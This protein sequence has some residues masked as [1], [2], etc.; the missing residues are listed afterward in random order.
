MRRLA[1][2][3]A[4]HRL[5]VEDVDD[6]WT[7]RRLLRPGTRVG[8]LGGRRD[9]STTIGIEGGRVKSAERK[10]MWIELRAESS[11]HQ[12]FADVLRVHGTITQAP[13]DVGSHHTH[14]VSVRDEVEVTPADVWRTEDTELLDEALASGRRTRLGIVVVEADEVTLYELGRH[15]LREVHQFTMRGGGKQADASSDVRRSFLKDAAA[16]TMDAW[17]ARVPLLVCGPGLTRDAVSALLTDVGDGREVRSVA[18]GIGG[19]GAV[20]EVL[21]AGEG[22]A[23]LADHAL[24][25]QARLVGEALE[26]LGRDGAVAYGAADLWAAVGEGAVE[27]A[28]VLADRLRE[29][30]AL[31]GERSLESWVGA[32]REAGGSLVQCSLDDE[33]G[34]QLAGFGG[35]LGLLRWVLR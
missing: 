15:A 20:H 4:S 22:D 3:G 34:A 32:V 31:L 25:R 13:F 19:I 1:M 28:L 30:E 16:R 33:S 2:K 23:W 10:R 7:L 11:E 24:A 29:D 18:T 9:P 6:L 5:L 12:A 14:L 27:T 35:V 17:D 8:M 21:A 26:R